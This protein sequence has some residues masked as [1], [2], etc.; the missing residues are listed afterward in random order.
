M[1]G[2]YVPYLMAIAFFTAAIVVINLILGFVYTAYTG[3]SGGGGLFQERSYFW[4]LSNAL[5]IEGAVILTIGAFL[6]F[7]YRSRSS[8]VAKG[9]MSVYDVFRNVYKIR[10]IPENK[11][12][13]E[14]SGGWMLIF[15][16]AMVILFSLIFA[17]ISMK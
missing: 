16:G 10:D 7:F 1:P 11:R 17:L 14:G 13:E 5:F 9:M 8:Q 12:A 15:L 2:K 4:A 3:L 6:E